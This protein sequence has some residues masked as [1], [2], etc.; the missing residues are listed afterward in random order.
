MKTCQDKGD[1]AVVESADVIF[2]HVV[3]MLTWHADVADK[4]TS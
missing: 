2:P 1:V 4:V 3:T